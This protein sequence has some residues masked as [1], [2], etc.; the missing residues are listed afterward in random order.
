MV[1]HVR[2]TKSGMTNPAGSKGAQTF[3]NRILAAMC[4]R[5]CDSNKNEKNHE[6]HEQLVL[7]SQMVLQSIGRQSRLCCSS[8]LH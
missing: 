8:D 3:M 2:N 7:G 5:F 6:A 1:F 4:P